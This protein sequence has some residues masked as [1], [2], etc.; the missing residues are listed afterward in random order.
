MWWINQTCLICG[1]N[2]CSKC[3]IIDDELHVNRT[4]DQFIETKKRPPEFL[5]QLFIAA[6]KFVENNWPIV[7]EMQPIGRID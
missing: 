1:Q 5:P 4:C 6:R 3:Q 2:V 7:A